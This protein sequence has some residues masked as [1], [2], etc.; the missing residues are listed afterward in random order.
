MVTANESENRLSAE[1]IYHA[2]RQLPREGRIV[3]IEMLAGSLREDEALDPEVLA[4]AERR[5]TEIET[6]TAQ[7]LTLSELDHELR[8]KYQWQ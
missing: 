1:S 4:E 8:A 5:W 2:A 7:S 6:G 3:L